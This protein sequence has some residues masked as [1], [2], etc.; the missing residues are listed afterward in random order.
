MYQKTVKLQ[1]A[2]LLEFEWEEG[3][4]NMG[5]RSEAPRPKRK[6]FS[7]PNAPLDSDL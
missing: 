6:Q 3:L 7:G 5:T 4:A 2:D 1:N